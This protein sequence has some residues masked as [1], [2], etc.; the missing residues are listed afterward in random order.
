[1]SGWSSWATGVLGLLAAEHV[2]ETYREVR[3]AS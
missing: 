1:M 2:T 3:E